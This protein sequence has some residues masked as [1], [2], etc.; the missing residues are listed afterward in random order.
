MVALFAGPDG[1]TVRTPKRGGGYAAQVWGAHGFWELGVWATAREAR[2]H[3][4]GFAA[5]DPV[6]PGPG[7]AWA[8]PGTWTRRRR[9]PAREA[10]GYRWVRRVKGDA[11]QARYWLPGRG[12]LNLG[13]FT[14]EAHGDLAEWA[15][16]RAS[17]AFDELWR[18][19]TTVAAAVRRLQA[20]GPEPWVPKGVA[21]PAGW[22]RLR[23]PPA[24]PAGP[25]GPK[26]RAPERNLFGERVKPEAAARNR[27]AA[28]ARRAAYQADF[29]QALKEGEPVTEIVALLWDEAA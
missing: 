2:W 29:E 12:S 26:G 10:R 9:R 7:G 19:R 23:R 11:V 13:L 21:V 15:A 16:H 28:A 22:G 6:E 17:K 25:G 27:A 8:G 14:R 24:P 20:R 3:A 18:G 4:K 5:A 1:L